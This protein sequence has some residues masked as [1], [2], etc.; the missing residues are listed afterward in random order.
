MAHRLALD[1][2]CCTCWGGHRGI[3]SSRPPTSQDALQTAFWLIARSQRK[4]PMSRDPRCGLGPQ[5]KNAGR[6]IDGS[7]WCDLQSRTKPS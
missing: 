5:E 3:N 2:R 4:L 1:S 6:M 7:A